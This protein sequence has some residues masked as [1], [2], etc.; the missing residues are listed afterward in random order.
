MP[1]IT[2]YSSFVRL[3]PLKPAFL[4]VA[5]AVSHENQ[6]K[7]SAVRQVASLVKPCGSLAKPGVALPLVDESRDILPQGAFS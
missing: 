2:Y 7:T 3:H 5:V 1:E 6:A 4:A